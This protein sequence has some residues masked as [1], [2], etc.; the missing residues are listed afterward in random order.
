MAIDSLPEDSVPDEGRE[1]ARASPQQSRLARGDLPQNP[2]SNPKDAVRHARCATVV[3]PDEGN[4]RN[5]SGDPYYRAG[6]WEDAK[7][8][9]RSM[10]PRMKVTASIG[11][12]LRSSSSSSV[13]KPQ[14]RG[15]YDRAVTWFHERAPEDAELYQ[16]QIEAAQEL[17]LPQA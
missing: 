5:T 17:G 16:F 3:R 8:A 7:G 14:R 11:Y 12:S 4:N 9:T 15:W 2:V 13:R 6:E 1:P 10:A